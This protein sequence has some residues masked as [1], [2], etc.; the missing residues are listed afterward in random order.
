MAKDL[1]IKEKF[2]ELRSNG[3]SYDKVAKELQVNKSTLIEWGKHHSDEIRSLKNIRLET[4]REKYLINKEENLKTTKL[5]Y[6]KV[7]KT[8]LKR[9][10]NKLSDEKLFMIYMKLCEKLEDPGM[11]ELHGWEYRSSRKKIIYRS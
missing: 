1:D 10:L 2:I 7:R 6:K 9:D 3:I 8:L 11:V 4:L 5:L